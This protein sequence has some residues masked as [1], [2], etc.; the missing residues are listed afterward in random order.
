MAAPQ[1]PFNER[2][3]T[4][5]LCL[6][7]GKAYT[8]SPSAYKVLGR[9][10]DFLAN[11]EGMNPLFYDVFVCPVCLFSAFR[12]DFQRLAPDEQAVCIQVSEELRKG[13]KTDFTKAE[14]SLFVALAA[15]RQA[16]RF[17]AAR[18][19][20][21]ETMAMANLKM[22][23]LCRLGGDRQREQTYLEA[24]LY[25]YLRAHD[26]NGDRPVKEEGLV[27]YLIG[28]LHMRIGDPLAAIPWFR[29]V[30]ELSKSRLIRGDIMHWNQER[31][32]E[33]EQASRLL[34]LLRGVPLFQPLS[35]R[36]LGRLEMASRRRD[37]KAGDELFA[38]GEPG[39]WMALVVSGL[40]ETS[41]GEDA[42]YGPG[43]SLGEMS[44]LTGEPRTCRAVAK[45]NSRLVLIDKAPFKAL[46]AANP[47]LSSALVEAYARMRRETPTAG[48][49]ANGEHLFER[50]IG[51]FKLEPK[52]G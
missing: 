28:D 18:T 24:A 31:L 9:E 44:L 15:L 3:T 14:R 4:C 11:Y 34:E 7:P 39:D 38:P 30:I 12:E 40:I 13:P 47:G 25:H 8:P 51:F 22:A 49:E 5:P 37:L 43:M 33:A 10:S 27:P 6:V 29:K 41:E 42:R 20:A 45:E 35:D 52:R 50:L 19:A 48:L 23:K 21:D 16:L 2:D 17:Y 46:L 32:A 36:E 26:L 1:Q